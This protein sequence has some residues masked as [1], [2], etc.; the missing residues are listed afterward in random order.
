MSN[1]QMLSR[2]DSAMIK[3][4]AADNDAGFIRNPK[5]IEQKFLLHL[6]NPNV[7]PNRI[8]YGK[9]AA[10]W[11]CKPETLKRLRKTMAFQVN[12]AGTVRDMLIQSGGGDILYEAMIQ[13]RIGVAQGKPWA[14]IAALRI[15]GVMGSKEAHAPD[16]YE[17]AVDAAA[18][19]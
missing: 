3:A 18:G 14:V 1:V 11:G 9:L 5:V 10:E 12:L 17:K 15:G 8:P 19:E 7:S 2:E 16:S 4:A 6:A 13:L